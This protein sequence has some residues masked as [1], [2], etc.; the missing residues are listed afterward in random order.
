MSLGFE[1][2]KI[3]TEG[4]VSLDIGVGESGTMVRGL[5]KGYILNLSL[6]LLFLVWM[7]YFL[8]TGNLVPN[9]FGDNSPRRVSIEDEHPLVPPDALKD[10]DETLRVPV[11]ALLTS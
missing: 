6:N 7:A 11:L 10:G 3:L 8:A 4:L 1:Y 9:V 5:D 2:A